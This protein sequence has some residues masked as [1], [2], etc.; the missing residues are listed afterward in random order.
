M[1]RDELLKNLNETWDWFE[2]GDIPVEFHSDRE[3]MYSAVS[4]NSVSALAIA[5][6]ELKSDRDFVLF[7]VERNGYALE[8][9]SEELLEDREFVLKAIGLGGDI[10]LEVAPDEFRTDKDFVL[11]LLKSE[12]LWG[13]EALSG[14]PGFMREDRAF[15]LRAVKIDRRSYYAASDEL[16]DDPIIKAVAGKALLE[17]NSIEK[18]TSE[19]LYL[20]AYNEIKND[21][22]DE[23]LFGRALAEAEGNIEEAKN[24]YVKMR[25]EQF[26]EN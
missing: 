23:V 10:A 13:G 8:H 25:V 18:P 12:G 24:N 26:S 22:Y 11:D 17:A 2:D 9:A 7:A 20:A 3:I 21:E 16:K 1:N 15:V 5:S 6:D 19:E 4:L 14:A